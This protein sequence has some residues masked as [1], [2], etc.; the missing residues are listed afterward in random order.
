VLASFDK[1]NGEY[2]IAGLIADSAG[3]LYGTASGGGQYNGGVAFRV[4]IR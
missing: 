1:T 3:V 2:P 4:P